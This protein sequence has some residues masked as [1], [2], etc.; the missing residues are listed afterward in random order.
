[1]II[2]EVNDGAVRSGNA[3]RSGPTI[4]LDARTAG[5]LALTLRELANNARRYGAL[6]A[7]DGALRIDWVCY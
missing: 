4:H 3:I 2:E 5:K 1:M 6:P 7:P